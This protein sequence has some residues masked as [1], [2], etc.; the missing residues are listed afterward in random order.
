MKPINNKT[1]SSFIAITLLLSIAISITLPSAS[2]ARTEYDD[3]C[4]LALAPNTVG[5]GQSVIITFWC[6]KLPPTAL[7]DYGDRW[8]FDVNIIKPDGT[9]ETIS[10]IESDPVGAGYTMYTPD[11]EGTY[12]IQAIMQDHTI[13]GGASRGAVA[14]GGAGWW[15]SGQPIA[16]FNPV[17]IVFKGAV[18]QYETLN[19]T[20]SPIPRYNETPLP[21]DYWTRPIYDA[22]RGWSSVIMGQW[23]NANE[24]A[25]YG[26]GNKYN[27]YTTGPASSH[28]LWT[29]PYFNGGLAGGVSTVNTSSA[30]NSYY[31]GQ[32][33]ESF[34]GPSIVLNG[35]IYWTI[36]TNPREGFMCVDLYT[37]E[38]IYFRN[39]TGAVGGIGTGQTSTGRIIAGAPSMGQVLTYDSPNQHGTLG[40]YWVTNTEG[41]TWTTGF[42]GSY[43]SPRWDMYD[44]FSGNYICSIANLTTVTR[45]SDNRNVVQGATG[46]SAVGVDGS[47]LR[48]NIVNLG[49]A[50]SPQWYLQVWNTTQAIMHP[51]YVIH[52]SGSGTNTNWL[53]RPN[54]NQTYDGRYGFS[55]NV[56]LST[57]KLQGSTTNIRQV[58]PDDK[59]IVI[60]AG[61]NN[62]TASTSLPGSVYAID[63]RPGSVGNI[64]YSYNFSAPAT[65]SDSFG[66]NE[67]Y[68]SKGTVFGGINEQAGIFWYTDSMNRLFYIYDLANGKLLWTMP[69]GPQMEFYGMG[70]L[71]VYNGQLIDTGNYGGVVRAFDA[72]T[73]E[74]LWNWTA[75]SVG[76]GETSY[77][78]TPTSYGCL[79]GDGLLYLYSNEH[80]VNNP[81][82]RDA[83]I[84]CVN[85]TSGQQVW[86]LTDWP[87][88]SPILADG[89]LLVVDSHDMELYCFGKGPSATTVSAPQTV[90][91]LGS[92]VVITGTVT[93]QTQYGRR[94]S[95]GS[96]DFSLK[97]TPAIADACMDDWMEYMFHQRPMPTD[98][99][100]VAVSLDTID[101]N[102]N[103]VH[104]GDTTSDSA[105]NYGF[106]YT[107]EVPGTYQII[108][109][110]D[111]SNSYGPSFGTTYL[112]IG[113]EAT[114]APTSTPQPQSMTDLY[115]V[116]AV[117]GIIV[118]I[119]LVGVVIVL[120]VRKRP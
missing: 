39:T 91:A 58:I 109:T 80:S 111:G 13:D 90:P 63:L 70:T 84:W 93:D 73:G 86:A 12:V 92:S 101:P 106:T 26:N 15:P 117:I 43:S 52:N 66:Q 59:L 31:S 30:D 77:Q 76:E 107:P 74:F 85:V 36:E 18:S 50:A 47:I 5:T 118:T 10:D 87:S 96:L 20:S 24:L 120:V 108:A 45:T 98:A 81:I 62:G 71:I 82:R 44:D 17:G 69:A 114:T 54:L 119:V 16:N 9:N 112:A 40:Y 115:F 64:L 25:Q 4:Y 23:L 29:R 33:Y 19:V 83:M 42:G 65:C 55:T 78:Y 27:P 61:V 100:G 97:G 116:P 14:P 48:Y 56:S 68:S 6:D 75:P 28:I 110:F 37:G 38:T 51:F 79:S 49:T 60:Y 8:T 88:G 95:T 32:S 3:M 89:R 103:Y 67:Q 34:S 1:L 35:K 2:A 94:T 72:K 104:I 7:G 102:G 57:L 22:N 99:V 11:Q 53:W 21:N 105:G 41:G 46:T 113:N